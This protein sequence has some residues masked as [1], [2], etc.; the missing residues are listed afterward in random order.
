MSTGN[1]TRGYANATQF[2]E[3]LKHLWLN[4]L[5]G[6]TKTCGTVLISVL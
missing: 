5:A 1:S 4:D 6:N 2:P 3:I